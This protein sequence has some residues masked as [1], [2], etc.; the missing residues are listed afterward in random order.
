MFA[1]KILFWIW[2]KFVII[3]MLNYAKDLV[4]F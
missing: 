3:T 1:M 2:N 4:V